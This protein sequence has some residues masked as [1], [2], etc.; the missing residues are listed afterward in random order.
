MNQ[1]RELKL[2]GEQGKRK[3]PQA[4][5]AQ[6]LPQSPPPE[7]GPAGDIPGWR[8]SHP[9]SFPA[10]MWVFGPAGNSACLPW[11]ALI[12]RRSCGAGAGGR[13]RFV[14]SPEAVPRGVKSMGSESDRLEFISGSTL[15]SYVSL[16]KLFNLSE[17]QFSHNN[18]SCL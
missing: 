18:N 16:G 5:K 12:N 1:S 10:L 8:F 3:A 6:P 7:G 14:I 9:T 11:A 17:L 15:S 13:G 4:P 2:L